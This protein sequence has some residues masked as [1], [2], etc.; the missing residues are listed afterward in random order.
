MTED[1]YIIGGPN[2]LDLS[3]LKGRTTNELPVNDAKR[4]IKLDGLSDSQIRE[5]L[6]HADELKAREQYGGLE[7]WF[8]PGTKYGID[9]LPKHKAFFDSGK[10][11]TE[12]FFSSGNRTGKTQSASFEAACHLTGLYPDWWEGRRFTR[13]NHAWAM[14]LTNAQTRDVIQTKL[15]GPVGSWGTGMIPKELI[16][17]TSTKPGAGG[18]IDIVKVQHIS[19]GIS[20]LGFKSAEQG[21]EFLQGVTLDWAWMDEI[22]SQDVYSE[23]FMRLMTTRGFI[24]LT[25][26]PLEGMTPLVLAYF[27]VAKF[28]PET[29]DLPSVIKLAREDRA[30]ELAE[31]IRKGDDATVLMG[32]KNKC[33]VVAGWDDCPWL[34]EEEKITMLA[35]RPEHLREASRTGIPGTSGGNIYPIPLDQ[36]LIDDFPIPPHYRLINGMDVGWSNTAAAFFA[37]DPDTSTLYMYGEYKRGKAEPIIHAEAIKTKSKWADAPVAIDPA[38]QG[39]SQVDGRQLYNLYRQH[40]LKL[41]KADNAVEAGIYKVWELLSIGKLKVF[42]SCKEFQREYIT[43]RRDDKGR[44]IKENDHILD[45]VR[46]ACGSLDHAR[47]SYLGATPFGKVTGSFSRK[48]YF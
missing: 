16:V 24:M 25:A 20:T 5:L 40:G 13:A 38:S 35:A 18:A 21:R 22:P 23:V 34:G 14:A 42:K 29:D 26:T 1:D 15:L 48:N 2:E 47:A 33:I 32:G 36:I 17:G 19:G 28:L 46:Y 3:L 30:R 6:K 11:F 37:L 12:R 44:V 43:Y 27:S 10:D 39:R 4:I 45:A 9:K 8:K 7:N 31:A 41:I